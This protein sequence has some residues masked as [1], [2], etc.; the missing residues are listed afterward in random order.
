MSK[1]SIDFNVKSIE[2]IKHTGKDEVI[3]FDG[4]LYLRVRASSKTRVFRSSNN[5]K[6]KFITILA[7]SPTLAPQKLLGD[8][9][10]LILN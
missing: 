7:R 5:G 10:L 2:R 6:Q 3:R 8:N 9:Y 1:P 4:N